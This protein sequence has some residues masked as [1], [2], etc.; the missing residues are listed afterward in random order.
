MVSLV[1]PFAKEGKERENFVK[2][3]ERK[4]LPQ[5]ITRR[6][7]IFNPFLIPAYRQAGVQSENDRSSSA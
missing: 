6:A 4:E 7:F 5:S 1:E 3:G 2:E